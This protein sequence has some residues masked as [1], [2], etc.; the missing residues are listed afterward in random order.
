LGN[1]RGKAAALLALHSIRSSP[2]NL[3][4]LKDYIKDL[5]RVKR[6]DILSIDKER[7]EHERDEH[8]EGG[9]ELDG[10]EKRDMEGLENALDNLGSNG[11]GK[12]EEELL[13]ELEGRLDVLE[14]E[15][16]KNLDF[17]TSLF[18]SVT[19]K[20]NIEHINPISPVGSTG[21]EHALGVPG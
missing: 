15:L 14:R 20:R 1:L 10:N 7:E 5:N 9:Y 17:H 11:A 6:V 4:A 19:P 3:D 8:G 21:I 12:R 16:G 18:D 2:T 13:E